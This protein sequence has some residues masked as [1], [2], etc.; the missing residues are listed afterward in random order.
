MSTNTRR[1]LLAA[2]SLLLLLIVALLIA[3]R[4]GGN[5]DGHPVA[6][7]SPSSS[8]KTP[9][10]K[11]PKEAVREAYLQQWNVYAGAVRNLKTTGL[12]RVF[13]GAALRAV[14]REVRDLGRKGRGVLVRVKHNLRVQIASA[15]TA[16]VIDRYENH[17][18]SFSQK[19]GKPTERD[20][21]ELIL[22]AYTLRKVHGTWKVSA[23]DRQSV[24]PLKGS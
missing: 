16:L 11:S 19:T 4:G 18:V 3:Q 17:S 23:I 24:R 2:V 22:E 9:S 1:V 20:P 13:T 12:D 21:N 15:S 5:G 6:S 10:S 7:V 14:H 8:G